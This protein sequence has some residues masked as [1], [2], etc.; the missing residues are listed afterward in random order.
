MCDD[1]ISFP[2]QTSG[3]EL[4]TASDSFKT[5]KS[6]SFVRFVLPIAFL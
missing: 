2:T 1:W 6:C 4:T 3:L 5:V